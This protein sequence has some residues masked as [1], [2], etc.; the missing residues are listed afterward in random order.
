M[1]NLLWAG[2]GRRLFAAFASLIA[3]YA[4][5]AGVAKAD[6]EAAPVALRTLQSEHLPVGKGGLAGPRVGGGNVQE[7]R[8][9][10]GAGPVAQPTTTAPPRH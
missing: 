7:G 10:L 4:L 2:T 6:A 5:T 8:P 1:K 3:L 9:A